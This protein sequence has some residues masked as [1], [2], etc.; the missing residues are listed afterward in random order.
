MNA[1][2]IVEN[3]LKQLPDTCSIEDV[4]YRLYVVETLRQRVEMADQGDFASQEEAE[5]R[6]EKWLMR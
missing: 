1:K 4:Q 3:V 2:Q 6:M 5:K